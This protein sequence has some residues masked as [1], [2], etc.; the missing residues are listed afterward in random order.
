[1]KIILLHGD[2]ELKSYKRLQK[3]VET[4]K[5]RS[6]EVVYLDDSNQSLL[7]DIRSTSLFG[8]E[9]FFILKDIKKIGKIES[10]WLRKTGEKSGGNLIIYHPGVTS[11]TFI[12]SL[13]A[14]TKVEEFKLPKLIFQF[15]DSFV[16]KN[17]K[18]AVNLL[19]E[20]STHQPPEFLFSL[21][22]RH[23][24]DLYWV[25]ADA[26]TLP[27]PSWRV[28]KL[29]SQAQ[30]FQV[31]QLTELISELSKIDIEVKTSNAELI[32]SLDLL[33]ATRLE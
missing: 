1:M 14:S 5:A 4:A 11:V 2:D 28:G 29:R 19:H 16:P 8:G 32:P 27:Y 12:S 13:P 18:G 3:F 31:N 22:A 7:E 21:L 20:V 33:I 25:T 30:R 9:R 6:W 24:R 10:E 23:I 26:G 17:A 15:L